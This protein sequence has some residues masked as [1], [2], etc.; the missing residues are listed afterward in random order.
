MIPPKGGR[1]TRKLKAD[2]PNPWRAGDTISSRS[3][4]PGFDGVYVVKLGS[5]RN[6]DMKDNPMANDPTRMV[7]LTDIL[8][9]QDA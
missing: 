8:Q 9:L 6:A 5:M 2:N 1:E 7:A 3:Y 4:D